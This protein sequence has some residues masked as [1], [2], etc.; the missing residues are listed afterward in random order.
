MDWAFIKLSDPS[1]FFTLVNEIEEE[2]LD[3]YFKPL[4]GL[5]LELKDKSMKGAI[6]HGDPIMEP[7][8]T[9]KEVE[10]EWKD[11]IMWKMIGRYNAQK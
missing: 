11:V 1:Y 5:L 10:D 3:F 6:E 4:N 7:S 2:M 8:R 9:Q